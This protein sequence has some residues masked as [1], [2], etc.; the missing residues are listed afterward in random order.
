MDTYIFI[1]D[2]TRDVI[3][4]VWADSFGEALE[5]ASIPTDNDTPVSSRT[6]HGKALDFLTVC[7][8]YSEGA[9]N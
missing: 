6:V 5:Y 1:N 7:Q 9:W 3:D 2:T 4:S 8:L